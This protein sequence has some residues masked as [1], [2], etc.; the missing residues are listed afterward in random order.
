[1]HAKPDLRVLLK[2]MITRSGSVITDVIHLNPRRLVTWLLT[3]GLIALL[4]SWAAKTVLRLSRRSNAVKRTAN[5]LMKGRQSLSPD[6]FAET[7]FPTSQ[8]VASRLFQILSNELIVD[9]S[10]IHPTDRLYADL[11]LGVIDGLDPVHLAMDVEQVFSAD[12]ADLLQDEH[13]TITDIVSH[14]H[15]HQTPGG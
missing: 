9:V 10:R 1:M 2:W 4:G 15:S 12:I 7:H 13:V 8:K 6:E 5:E 3:I 11:G 14:I